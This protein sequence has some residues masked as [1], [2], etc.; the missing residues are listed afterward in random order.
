MA[1][2][3]AF[4][5]QVMEYAAKAKLKPIER[6]ALRLALLHPATEQ[7]IKEAL[8]Q[9]ANSRNIKATVTGGAIDWSELLAAIFTSESIKTI[10]AALL[11]LLLVA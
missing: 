1:R 7:K 10:F 4:R 8:V 11:R 2:R 3:N 6:A 9:E 5:E